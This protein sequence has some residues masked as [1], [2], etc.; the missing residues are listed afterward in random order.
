MLRNLNMSTY[1]WMTLQS[2]SSRVGEGNVFSHSIF[3]VP[4]IEEEELALAILLSVGE[5]SLKTIARWVGNCAEPMWLTI[6]IQWT[7][8]Q[9]ETQSWAECDDFTRLNVF[10][11][12][13]RAL[14]A[15]LHRICIVWDML[16][17]PDSKG[18]ITIKWC[19]YIHIMDVYQNY[20]QWLLLYQKYD[21]LRYVSFLASQLNNNAISF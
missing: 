1:F 11:A 4:S 3:P 19:N 2:S 12:P 21:I 6:F 7:W 17:F 14:H 8:V 9:T 18:C 15:T 13:H 20:Q 10:L 16:S 5:V